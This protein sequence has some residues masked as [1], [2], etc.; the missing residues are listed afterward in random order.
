MRIALTR[1]VP[2]RIVECEL[3][4][5]DRVAIDLDRA[6]AQHAEYEAALARAGCGIE[7]IA[8]APELADSVFVEDAA[9]VLPELA[10]ITRPGA[11]SRR[12]ETAS[13]AAALRRYRPLHDID[14]PGTLDGGDVLVADRRVFVG[15]SSRTN[16]AGVRQLRDILAPVGYAV[17]TVET[18]GCLHLKSAVTAVAEGLL[19]VNPEWIDV[20]RF[21]GFRVLEVDPSEPFAA[22][23]LRIGD[24]VICALAAPLTRD[25]IEAIGVETIAVDVSELAKA[26]AGVTCSSLI[27]EQP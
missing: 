23:V 9:V 4:H 16:E 15:L 26:E 2:D 3:T 14:A 11:A 1:D 19:L 12:A 8:P 7:R 18:R 10:V 20:T 13:V 6:R 24:I 25:R 17:E 27:I 22:N 5:L 21:G